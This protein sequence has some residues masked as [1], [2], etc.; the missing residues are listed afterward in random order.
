MKYLMTFALSVL[1]LFAAAQ[2]F[3]QRPI[4]LI[5]GV[6]PGGGQETIIR[7]MTP[8]LLKTLGVNLIV[9][10]RPGG[11][12]AIAVEIAKQAA[13]DGYTLLM[14]SASQ[15]I[16]PLVSGAPY[17]I[18][19]DFSPVTQIITQPYLLVATPSLPVKSVADL[20]S[21]GKSNPGKLN[22]GSAG[23]ATVTHLAAEL[24]RD[25]ARFDATHIPYKGSGALYPDLIAGRVQ[26]AFATINSSQGHVKANRLRAL[27]ISSANRSNAAPAIPT[28]AESGLPGYAVTQWYGVLAPAKTPRPIVTRLNTGFVAVIDDPEMAGHFAKDGA[29]GASS[30]PQQ[31]AAFLKSEQ[32]RWGSLVSAA[33]L[34]SSK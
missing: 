26:W 8:K 24:F 29:E 11:S 31:F 23:N 22:F 16:N 20:I 14:I 12:G 18:P 6:A 17:D 3:P 10:N 15:I 28:L 4:R 2:D 30:T 7:G 9:D 25:R 13:P 27:A 33:G 1:P 21:Y 19:R 34:K 5:L 32:Q